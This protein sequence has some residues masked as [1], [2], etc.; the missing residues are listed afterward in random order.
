MR[1]SASCSWRICAPPTDAGPAAFPGAVRVGVDDPAGQRPA[2]SSHGHPPRRASRFPAADRGRAGPGGPVEPRC[3]AGA[4][5]AARRG[6]KPGE[7]RPS[8]QEAQPPP[9]WCG[10]RCRAAAR[11]W[12]LP[13]VPLQHD[14]SPRPPASVGEPAGCDG[15]R[16]AGHRA[17]WPR[18]G[19]A[20]G[21]DRR[22]PRA[23]VGAAGRARAAPPGPAAAAV[24]GD[25][26]LPGQPC[27]PRAGH[28]RRQ[29]SH[30]G[31]LA[32]RSPHRGTD[33]TGTPDRGSPRPAARGNRRHAPRGDHAAPCHGHG[34]CRPCPDPDAADRGHPVRDD[35]HTRSHRRGGAAPSRRGV[36]RPCRG[37]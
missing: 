14:L 34:A 31:R 25:R 29:P 21:A 35:Q 33:A 20:L 3:A 7:A 22:R 15:R 6:D 24:A 36:R 11:G 19:R 1:R 28:G 2:G 13:G 26:G 8:R 12:C 27:P 10:P 37:S 9:R 23:G 18:A 5:A 17:A 16:P 30:A 32:A 4:S